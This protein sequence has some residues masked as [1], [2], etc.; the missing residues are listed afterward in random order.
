MQ[1]PECGTDDFLLYLEE[2]VY[3]KIW[4][5]LSPKERF[6]VYAVAASEHGSV[7]QILK[8]SGLSQSAFSP[9]RKRLIQKGILN[10]KKSDLW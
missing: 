2:Y 1:L 3:E 7:E 8:T 10:G 9:Y 5:E 6:V 4:A